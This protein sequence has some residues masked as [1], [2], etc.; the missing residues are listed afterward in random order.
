MS[1]KKKY[2]SW[3]T[4]ATILLVK[5]PHLCKK[6][7]DG[8]K[9]KRYF[10]CCFH[11]C[12]KQKLL[13]TIGLINAYWW[14]L[15]KFQSVYYFYVLENK[16]VLT[17]LCSHLVNNWKSLSKKHLPWGGQKTNEKEG[18]V[19]FIPPVLLARTFFHFLHKR[20]LSYRSSCSY[21]SLLFFI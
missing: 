19:A 7:I 6:K 2:I 11:F 10:S 20:T 9:E 14:Y 15:F 18:E 8:P 21:I 13:P 4:L 5:I 17:F 12:T 16:L 1:G 3:E